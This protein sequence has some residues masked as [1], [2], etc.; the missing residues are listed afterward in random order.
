MKTRLKNKRK[1]KLSEIHRT[2]NNDANFM[3]QPTDESAQK[4]DK[5][6]QVSLFLL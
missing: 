3:S 5:K 2:H 6:L 1:T 4:K